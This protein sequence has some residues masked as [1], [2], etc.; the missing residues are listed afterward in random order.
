L[1]GIEGT[2]GVSDF[3]R[4]TTLVLA[5]SVC[6]AGAAGLI[7]PQ[8]A[9]ADDK[10]KSKDA[11]EGGEDV[12]ANEDMMREHGVLRRILILYREVAPRLHAARIDANAIHQSAKLF[13]QFGEQYHEK[14]L[15]E[16]YVFPAVRKA[17]GE[18][19]A[20]LDL[21]VEQ[22]NRGREITNYIIDAT[23]NGRIATASADDLAR[24][25][26]A[27]A[28]MYETHAAYEDT[29]IYPAFKKTMSTA[30]YDE[31]G[32]TFEEI[33]HKQFGTDGFDMAVKKVAEAE[34]A[35]GIADL[36]KFTAPAPARHG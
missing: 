12:A 3:D 33:E 32:D 22:H 20:L 15:E 10:S 1:A 21:L 36:A 7:T 19:V 14:K 11:K 25:M 17:G 27:F 28:R 13:Q 34:R 4:R 16:Q 29:I 26:I 9:F 6:T 2:C 24:A 18:S 23:K 5:V 8:P 30:Q 31:L 35:L